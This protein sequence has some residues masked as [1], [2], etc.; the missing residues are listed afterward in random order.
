MSRAQRQ[1][2]ERRTWRRQVIGR[3]EK[4]PL[5][6][7]HESLERL[8]SDLCVELGYCLPALEQQH[9]IS[10]PPTDPRRFAELVMQLEGV[11]SADAEMFEPVLDRVC[12]AFLQESGSGV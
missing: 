9:I 8:L 12:R 11:G 3:F 1:E 5:R 10:N 7:S 4:A 6:L 2:S